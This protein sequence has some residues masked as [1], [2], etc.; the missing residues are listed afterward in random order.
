MNPHEHRR[1]KTKPVNRFYRCCHRIAHF[2]LWLFFGINVVGEENIPSGAS[3]VCANHSSILDPFII[4]VAFGI[5]RNVHVIAKAELYKIPVV[6]QILKKLEMIRVDRGVLDT[7]TV[8]TTFD[9]LKRGE[10][11]VIFPEGTRVS[12][13]ETVAAKT[14]A[15][16]IAERC[17][18]PIVPL[19]I[20]RKKPV[21]RK[22]QVVI[23]EPY[24]IEKQ[25]GKRSAED[26]SDL[27]AHL[28]ERIKSLDPGA[29]LRSASKN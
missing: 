4:A 7:A 25:T 5:S 12:E 6:S 9:Y 19:F 15:I 28:M 29:L 20:P 11:V 23:G 14:G 17:S 10:I 24:N 21:F 22:I 16:K 1:R 18:V 2:Y 26:Y 3:M 8:R 13:D 27:S